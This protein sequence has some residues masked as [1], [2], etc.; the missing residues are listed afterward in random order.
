MKRADQIIAD[1][2]AQSKKFSDHAHDKL[3]FQVGWLKTNVVEL[4]FELDH[5]EKQ[6]KQL[7]VELTYEQTK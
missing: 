5:M 7:Q 6:I 3:A 2:E 4:C 1:G